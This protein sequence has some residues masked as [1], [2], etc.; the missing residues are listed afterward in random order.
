MANEIYENSQKLI[1]FSLL[2]SFTIS[3]ALFFYAVFNDYLYFNLGEVAT[4]LTN[5]GLM[6]VWVTDLIITLQNDVLVLIPASVDFLW[7]LSFIAFAFGFVQSAYYAKRMGYLS[8]LS[9]LTFFTMIILFLMT[10]FTQLSTWFQ[11]QFIG[12]ILPNL[13]YSTPFFSFY[14]SHVGIINIIL[15]VLAVIANFVDL[16]IAKFNFRKEGDTGGNE[17]S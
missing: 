1:G 15:I 9:F 2:S 4:D 10:I 6:G 12:L 3:F 11:E 7:L 14:L 16:E 5:K 13:A 17:L 8:M